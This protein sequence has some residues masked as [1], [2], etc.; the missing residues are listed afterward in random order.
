[1]MTYAPSEQ[2]IE[3][4]RIEVNLALKTLKNRDWELART[5][6]SHVFQRRGFRLVAHGCEAIFVE[7]ALEYANLCFGEG[8]GFR[9]AAENL[10]RALVAAEHLGDRRARALI[11]LHL[12]RFY[13][14]SERPHEALALFAKG[15]A[16]VEEL[17]DEDILMQSAEFLGFYFHIQGLFV[18][19]RTY[20]EKAAQSYESGKAGRMSNPS[21]PIWL[22]YCTA[23]LGQFHQAIGTLDYYHRLALERADRSLA[24][25]IRAALG[26][27]LLFIQ[28]KDEA[29][30]HLSGA[31]QDAIKTG[32]DLALYFVTGY[33]AYHHLLDGRAKE[34]WELMR[35]NLIHGEKT[36]L[37]R[38]YA[39]PFVLEMI[40]EYNRLGLD[41]LPGW[42]FHGQIEK[43]L[44]GPNVHLRGVALCLRAMDNASRNGDLQKI[45]ADLMAGEELLLRSGDPIHLA[46]V[47][48]EQARLALK[49]DEKEQA[50]DYAQKAWH[51]FSGYGE[52]FF[53]NDLR[54]LLAVKNPHPNAREMREE[55]LDRFMTMIHDLVPSSDVEDI[56]ARAVAATNRFFGAERG[57]LF[58]F[59]HGKSAQAPVLR[60]AWNLSQREVL[61]ELFKGSLA[62]VIK[63]FRENEPQL[64]RMEGPRRSPHLIKAL[65][66]LPF[67]VD[68]QARGVLYH[69]NSYL[70]DCF[71]FLEKPL[72]I[73]LANSLST[74]VGRIHEY[75]LKLEK[76]AANKINQDR[77]PYRAILVAGSPVMMDVLAQVDQVAGSDCTVLI[78]GE[79]GVGKELLAQR[80]HRQSGRR[81]D[82]FVILDAT[83]IPENLVE[84]ELFGHEKGAFTGADRRKVGRLELAHGGTVFID[85]VSE[86]PKSIQAKF[87]R[88]LQEK[89]L[90]RV[91]GMQTISSDFR[92]VAASNRDLA[93]EVAAG[94][95]R[96]D[97]YY[98]LN[99]VPVTLPPLRERLEDVPLLA[100]HFLIRYTSKCG[101]ASLELSPEDERQLMD[102][103][104]PGNVREL[105]NIIERSVLL[106]TEGYLE[107]NLPVAKATHSRQFFTDHPTLD[108]M[109]CRYIRYALEKSN[110]KI[111]GLGG[112]AEFLG[113]KRTTLQKRMKSLGLSRPLK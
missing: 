79:T 13:Y 29:A 31:W 95:F 102:Y 75:S 96:E 34:S 38:Q 68:G 9:D 55:F 84:S 77:P 105:Q 101:R 40:Y 66:C 52:V 8:K 37:V 6:L 43:H 39:S 111:S 28:K 83:T 108:E 92:L 90:V 58:W 4:I 25:T 64:V 45:R 112:A 94:R 86:I 87:L 76:S 30:F 53:P 81:D 46:K 12:G 103:H 104:W 62:L 48:V 23:Y 35:N 59:R 91:G 82:P 20:F 93:A 22:G 100:R 11:W 3:A 107:L 110:G 113:M 49:E 26:L 19:A 72:L 70:N 33:L 56:L 88:V 85:E 10:Q 2:E 65:L 74:Y 50:R 42:D 80:V 67:E 78:L 41:H 7:A 51:G 18:E 60:A 27:V 63:A 15:M 44:E 89:T 5:Q 61:S 36:G 99:V 1:M 17:G 97:L 98:R 57:G 106:S 69:D 14:F 16:E 32:N 47:R 109:Q 54:C 73:R 21:G 71:D 24:T